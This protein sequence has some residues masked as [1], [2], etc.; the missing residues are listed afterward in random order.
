MN[1]REVAVT[2][3]GGE[4]LDERDRD[5]GELVGRRGDRNDERRSLAQRVEL[6]LLGLGQ[7]LRCNPPCD[8]RVVGVALVV[9]IIKA[10]VLVPVDRGY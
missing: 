1:E 10:D 2:R 4:G 9:G 8:R 5:P 7:F 6:S 3:D